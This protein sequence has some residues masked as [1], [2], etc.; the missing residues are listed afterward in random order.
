MITVPT[1]HIDTQ[2]KDAIWA[3]NCAGLEVLRLLNEL[4][5]A[6]IASGY[7]MET[8]DQSH[9]VLVFDFGDGTLNLSIMRVASSAVQVM[10]VNGDSHFGGRDFDD[11]LIELCLQ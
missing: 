9:R 10:A 2:R 6:A 1:D 4:S 3:A 5:A 7:E 11:I 8:A